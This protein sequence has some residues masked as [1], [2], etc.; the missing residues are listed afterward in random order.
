M[1]N[2]KEIRKLIEQKGLV[3]DYCNLD[4]QL[5]P[6]GLDVTVGKVF[7]F[8]APGALDF[9]NSERVV[10]EGKEILPKKENL[11]DKYGWWDLSRGAYKVRTNEVFNMPKDLIAIAFPRSSLLRIGAFT[12][13]GVWD[14]GFKGRAEFILVVENSKGIRLKENVRV[15]QVIFIKIKAPKQGYN[16]VYKEL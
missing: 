2:R 14:S 9:S 6:N 1:L 13:T 8:R 5:T 4:I 11:Q 12:Q 16:G 10:P 3:K 7:E 15:T